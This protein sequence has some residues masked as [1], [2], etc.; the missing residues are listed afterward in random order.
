MGGGSSWPNSVFAQGRSN[1]A[2]TLVSPDETGVDGRE[3]QGR[4][5]CSYPKS[6]KKGWGGEERGTRGHKLCNAKGAPVRLAA[7]PAGRSD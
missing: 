7:A 4:K 1:Y 5:A 2:I 6:D 3:K